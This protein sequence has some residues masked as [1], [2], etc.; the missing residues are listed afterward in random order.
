[1]KRWCVP[2]LP[3]TTLHHSRHAVPHCGAAV[4]LWLSQY[5]SSDVLAATSAAFLD[6]AKQF[7]RT[8]HTSKSSRSVAQAKLF[9][10]IVEDIGGMF[11]DAS[12]PTL[13]LVRAAGR[14]GLGPC[15][16]GMGV[17]ILTWLWLVLCQA[18]DLLLERAMRDVI[19]ESYVDSLANSWRVR[20]DMHGAD[21]HVEQSCLS[22]NGS[23]GAPRFAY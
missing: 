3:A 1:M 9:A 18:G 21:L 15:A 17:P 4:G 8:D 13:E 5:P 19:I 23:R 6:D 22:G 10:K 11:P 12:T 7:W 16:T 20:C 2:P 14:K